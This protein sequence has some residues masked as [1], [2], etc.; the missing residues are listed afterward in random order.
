MLDIRFIRDKLEKV[1]E[2]AKKKHIDIDWNHFSQLEQDRLRCIDEVDKLRQKRTQG[3]AEIPT[4]RD[5]EQKQ[6]RIKEMKELGERLKEKS[7]ILNNVESAY[8]DILLNI[9]NPPNDIV[10]TGKDDKENVEI[11]KWGEIPKFS[12]PFKSH[13]ELAEDLN[14]IDIPRAVKVAGTRNYFL[15]GD[16]VLLEMAVMRFAVDH[17]VKKGFIPFKCPAL[18]KDSA[19]IG[20][21]YYP[22]GEEQAYQIER[23]KLSLIGTSEVPL[24]S[25]HS[26]E[27]LKHQDLPK[28]Y[29][30]ISECYRRE[31]GTYGKDTKGLFRVHQFQKAEQVIIC[32]NSI[33]ESEKHHQMLLEN[34]KEIMQHLNI[35]YRVVIVCSGDL[36]MGQVIKHDI[37][38]WMPSRTNYSETH[39]CSTFYE[40]QARRLKTRYKDETG[41][42]Q[43]VHTL[44]NTAIASPRILIPL[45]ELN[46]NEDG[47]IT[48]PEVLVPYMGGKTKIQKTS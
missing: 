32:E 25:I 16:G 12:F 35:P 8:N 15:K 48:I 5:H 20:T 31:A 14:M 19:M 37:E 41:K 21:G 38:A 3:A 47:S 22:G 29:L 24:T 39:S 45:M 33:E 2:G 43:F 27:I 44:N 4:I 23:D 17:L 26:D 30:G 11:Y 40:F 18:A 10:P 34:A 1:K 6:K 7:S 46:Q 42:T 13:L 36:G 9:P 28:K